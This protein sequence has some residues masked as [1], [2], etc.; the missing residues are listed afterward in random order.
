MYVAVVG[1]RKF[2]KKYS[3]ETK[4]DWLD[5]ILAWFQH[6]RGDKVD[7]TALDGARRAACQ[8]LHD[9]LTTEL[10]P[11][12][13]VV[14]GGAYGAD[15]MAETWAKLNHNEPVVLEPDWSKGKHAGIIRNTEIIAKADRVIAFWD[16]ESVGTAHTVSL[17]RL[18][19]IPVLLSNF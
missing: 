8:Q 12:D 15:L 6:L 5:I 3:Y 18:K 11:E 2:N 9:V 19:N 16:G 10:Q 14:S 13:I 7:P 4:Q 1:S 17:A